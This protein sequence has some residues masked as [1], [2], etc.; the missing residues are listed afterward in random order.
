MAY[1]T[2]YWEVNEIT[3]RRNKSHIFRAENDFKAIKHAV[4]FMED[5]E[6][7]YKLARTGFRGMELRTII[8][9]TDEV[10]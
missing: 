4:E 5:V 1:Y 7:P 6:E 10:A 2:I 8:E 3:K 9:C